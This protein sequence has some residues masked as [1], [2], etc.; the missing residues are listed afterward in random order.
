MTF[1][2]PKFKGER[3]FSLLPAVQ[4]VATRYGSVLPSGFGHQQAFVPA[5]NYN[6]WFNYSTNPPKL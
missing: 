2:L 4:S 5:Q 1:Y 3:V 6:T